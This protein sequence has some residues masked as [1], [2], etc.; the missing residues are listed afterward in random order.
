MPDVVVVVVAQAALVRRRQHLMLAMAA[1]GTVLAFLVHPSHMLA[2]VAVVFIEILRP[3]D[4]AALAAAVQAAP[5][6]AAAQPL[7]GMELPTLAVVLAAVVKAHIRMVVAQAVLELSSFAIQTLMQQLHQRL[8]LRQYQLRVVTA[9]T[10]GP[11][12]APL[13]FKR[14]TWLTLLKSTKTTLSCASLS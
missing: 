2:V 3:M 7:V 10:H 11:D 4:L 1:V 5:Q 14:K 12:P 8:A 9:S 13:H 6:A